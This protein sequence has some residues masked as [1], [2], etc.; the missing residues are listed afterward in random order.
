MGA[1]GGAKTALIFCVV[2]KLFHILNHL[3]VLTKMKITCKMCVGGLWILWFK[4]S[5]IS[6]KT[7][8]PGLPKSGLYF[9]AL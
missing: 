5:S 8:I 7:S 3:P 1:G 9:T 2:V 6:I 4:K